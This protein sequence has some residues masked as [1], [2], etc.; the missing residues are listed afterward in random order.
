M[1]LWTLSFT[2]APGKSVLDDFL[3]FFFLFIFCVIGIIGILF[4][5]TTLM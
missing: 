3:S 4:S 2:A 1:L 5:G